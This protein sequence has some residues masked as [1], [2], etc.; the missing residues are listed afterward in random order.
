MA[1]IWKLLRTNQNFVWMLLSV[2]ATTLGEVLLLGGMLAEVLDR[3]GSALQTLLITIVTMITAVCVAPFSGVLADRMPRKWILAGSN[4]L[5]ATVVGIFFLMVRAEQTE[6]WHFYVVAFFYMGGAILRAPARQAIMPQIVPTKTLVLANSVAKAVILS[7]A[8]LAFWLVGMW[9]LSSGL[10]FVLACSTVGLF[11]GGLVVI[12][13]DL[14]L[15]AAPKTSGSHESIWTSI[16]LGYRFLNQHKVARPLVIMEGME[17]IPQGIWSYGMLLVFVERALNGNSADWGLMN[18]AYQ[19]SLL[20]GT[21]IAIGMTKIINQHAGRMII[22][23]TLFTALIGIPFVLSQSVTVATLLFFL[24]GL[25]QAMRDSAQDSVLQSS[26]DNSMLGRVYSFRSIAS[27]GAGLF[28][29]LLFAWLA[30]FVE[31][32]L[33]FM[34][35][36]G[37]F[38]LVALYA[39]SNEALRNSR[40]ITGAE[41]KVP[42]TQP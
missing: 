37:I 4:W 14:Q 6:L 25:P 24:F 21:L 7:C 10:G 5:R 33:L 28:S 17:S 26:I 2:G 36:A 8:A 31:I 40:I 41:E 32:R 29:T 16:Q 1:K 42:I 12:P 39:Y 18:S 13:I 9:M 35:G 23:D 30:D 19:T 27:Q 15:E 11:V 20:A 38:I 3:S 34:I 22:A